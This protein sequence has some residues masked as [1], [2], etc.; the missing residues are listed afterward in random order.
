MHNLRHENKVNENKVLYCKALRCETI[1]NNKK[2]FSLMSNLQ[3]YYHFKLD[4]QKVDQHTGGK[5][6]IHGTKRRKDNQLQSL[7]LPCRIS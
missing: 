6:L 1:K 2:M 7:E 5:W 3:T 4:F